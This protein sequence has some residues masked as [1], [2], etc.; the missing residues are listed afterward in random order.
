MKR[1]AAEAES[2]N[3][4]DAPP[5]VVWDFDWSLINENSD[6]YV[7][8]RLDPSGGIWRDAEKRLRRGA[9]WTGLM[10]WAAGELHAA[11]HTPCLLYTSPSPRDRG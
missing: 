7:I 6:T 8:E 10:D 2:S 5:L 11:G 3:A 1:R 9:D 4:A